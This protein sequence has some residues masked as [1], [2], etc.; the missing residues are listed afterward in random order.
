MLAKHPGVLVA[1]LLVACVLRWHGDFGVTW[2]E[3]VQ[4][5]YGQLTL[6]YFASAGEDTSANRF[7]DLKIYGPLVE[8]GLGLATRAAPDLRYDLR[9]LLLGLLSLLALPAVWLLARRVEARHAPW[10]AVAAL[11]T[12]P[13]WIGHAFNNSKDL[14]FAVA[15]AWFFVA[16]GHVFDVL[17]R[18]HDP[19]R[20]R[21][22]VL[23]CGLAMGLTLCAR[24]GAFPLLG[25]YLIGLLALCRP[26]LK[27]TL[28]G[29]AATLALAWLIMI[30]PW[31][32]AHQSPLL[33]PIE[34]MRGS[35]KF[36][37][38]YPLRF[39]GQVVSSDA[40][41]RHYALSMLGMATPLATL[42]LAAIGLSWKR[43]AAP[44]VLWLVA[45]LLVFAIL[46]PNIYDGIRHLLFLLPPLAILAG[47]GGARIVTWLEPYHC[48]S[49][50]GRRA[51]ALGTA[52]VLGLLLTPAPDIVRLH[53]YQVT[54]FNALVGGLDGATDR[55]ETDYW[56]SSYKEAIEWLNE[57]ADTEPSRPLLVVVSGTNYVRDGAQYYARENIHV[58]TTEDLY[59]KAVRRDQVDYYVVLNKQG[60]QTRFPPGGT[61]VV[62]TIQRGDAVLCS[63][64]SVVR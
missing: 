63:I 11:L 42:G 49:R 8:S 61:Q 60:W 3:W 32:W 46:E 57:R 37:I 41:P 9:H 26:S 36:A 40:L 13:R 55:Y 25:L 28:L 27:R 4:S 10:L 14:P 43:A 53:P 45:P 33:N 16:A 29:G 22:A 51:T 39:G 47:L 58:A 2:D 56:A 44:F 64:R 48:A 21:A 23:W 24:P 12:M 34:A 7:L 50:L 6:D 31:P 62:H 15:V 20:H 5:Q 19:Q 17:K 35:A 52:L 18:S 54:F 38:A 59:D 1:V 30:L